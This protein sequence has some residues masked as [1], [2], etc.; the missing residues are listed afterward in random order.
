M[1]PGRAPSRLD[2]GEARLVQGYPMWE[3]RLHQTPSGSWMDDFCLNL[4]LY[5]ALKMVISIFPRTHGF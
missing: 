3:G 2:P 5:G 4:S 1:P